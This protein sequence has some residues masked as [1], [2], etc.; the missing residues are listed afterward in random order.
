M[1][2]EGFKKYLISELKHYKDVLENT[3]PEDIDEASY[4]DFTSICNDD[5]VSKMIEINFIFKER[6]E[7]ES[8]VKQL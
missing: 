6:D 3:N 5:N 8:K 4:V 7:N 2:T 1:A